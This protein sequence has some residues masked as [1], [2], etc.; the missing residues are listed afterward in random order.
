MLLRHGAGA[1]AMTRD[2][3]T[4]LHYAV[5][6]GLQRCV[7]RLV[8]FEADVNAPNDRRDTPLH[9][10]CQADMPELVRYLLKKG[11][12]KH[13]LNAVRTRTLT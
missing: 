3:H 5:M 10:A 13:A 8:E 6:T 9:L 11:A 1:N 4:P 12:K 7:Q 2:G